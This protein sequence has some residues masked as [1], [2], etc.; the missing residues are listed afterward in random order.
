MFLEMFANLL[1][2]IYILSD[3]IVSANCK[4]KESWWVHSTMQ[5]NLLSE[6]TG[7][8][9]GTLKANTFLRLNDVFTIKLIIKH[10]GWAGEGGSK[11][12]SLRLLVHHG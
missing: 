1:Q 7:C 10:T 12:L 6:V 11:S 2:K 8:V 4:L 3:K 5:G 9:H